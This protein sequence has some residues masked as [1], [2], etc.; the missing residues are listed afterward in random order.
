MEAPKFYWL[1]ST[2]RGSLRLLITGMMITLFLGFGKRRAELAS[3]LKTGK[4]SRKSLDSYSLPLL[5]KFISTCAA[6]TVITY[7]LYTVDS[8]TVA[9]HGTQDLIWTMPVVVFGIFRYLYLIHHQGKGED[10][11]KD[12]FK[13]I[14]MLLAVLSWAVA[15]MLIVYA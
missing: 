3:A 13:D 8:E 7:G 15:V 1:M 9:V 5:D 10:T 11:S 6:G 4:Q 14:P 12:L 2:R